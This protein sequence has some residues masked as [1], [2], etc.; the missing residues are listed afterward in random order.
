MSRVI[1]KLRS[2]MA[3]VPPELAMFVMVCVAAIWS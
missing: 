3:M 2:A 1:I